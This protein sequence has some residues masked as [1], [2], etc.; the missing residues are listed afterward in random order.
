M[1]IGRLFSELRRRHVLRVA[2]AYAVV[3][4]LV[5]QVA[6]ATFPAFDIPEWTMRLV[7]ILAVL[8]FPIAIVLA[9]AF[10][11]TPGGVERTRPLEKAVGPPVDAPP[12][13]ERSL[14]ERP[15]PEPLPQSIAVLPFLNMSGEPENEYFSDGITEDLIAHL[16]RLRDL[17]VISRTSVMQYKARPKGMR[18]IASELGVATLLE[19][20]VRR[21]GGH[22]RIV[23]QLVDARSDHPLWSETYDRE[24]EDIFE[25]QA[26]VAQRI[27]RSLQA[28]LSPRERERIAAAPT[29]DLAAY[30]LYLK[31]RHE[32][33]RRTDASLARSLDHLKQAVAADPGFALALAGL[34]DSYVTL[35]IYGARSPHEVMP[36]ARAAAEK[37]LG[38]D[39]EQAEALTALACVRSVYEWDWLTA[40][41][42]YRRAIDLSPNYP[43]A[44]H[45]YAANFLMPL[46]RFEEARGELERAQELDPLAPSIAASFAVLELF[47]G[48]LER[49]AEAC[50]KVI[51]SSPGFWLAH[52]FLGCTFQELGSN[53]EAIA[54][55]E[56]ART[57]SADSVD[58]AAALGQAYA[59]AGR[60][61]DARAVLND[62]LARAAH[63]Y[64]SPMRLAQTHLGIGETEE[65]LS[66][67]ERA[68]EERAAGLVWLDVQ[69]V[70][71]GLRGDPRFEAVHRTVFG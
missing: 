9:W 14:S 62:L 16:A 13:V 31:G 26:D 34:A 71:K 15:V 40:E 27:A 51:A 3:A 56:K 45:W 49:A 29:R 10:D 28:E 38:I 23:A 8:G 69:P 2:A 4:W 55:L 65:A 59:A 1:K 5:I 30:D 33:N 41:E 66:C 53:D 12:A 54:S 60:A 44:H 32:W 11:M 21:A 46:R 52:Y 24:L 22:V 67:L 35:G 47:E 37:A 48:R 63:D 42:E 18:E 7:V 57:L 39:E 43:L 70:F 6:E 61:D 25:I 68:V 58:A 17:K 64:V 20:S 50:K 36:R 19:G